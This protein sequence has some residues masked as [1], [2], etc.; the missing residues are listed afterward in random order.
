MFLLAKSRSDKNS[1]KVTE[2]KRGKAAAAAVVRSQS[3]I[4]ARANGIASDDAVAIA[5][6]LNKRFS[7]RPLHAAPTTVLLAGYRV[8]CPPRRRM[9]GYACLIAALAVLAL[10]F[11]P[12]A[13][14]ENNAQ[15]VAAPASSGLIF[16]VK[17]GLRAVTTAVS[18]IAL[19]LDS[20]EGPTATAG[21]RN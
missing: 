18:R 20:R 3:R 19:P 9:A 7:P 15:T 10:N 17:Q 13:F 12:E 2:L 4:D 14:V 11:D 21:I 1:V 16:R 6:A 5:V 8:G